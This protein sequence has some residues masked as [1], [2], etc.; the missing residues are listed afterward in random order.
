VSDADLTDLTV[1]P[2]TARASAR[3]V[4]ITPMKARRVVDLVRGLPVEEALTVLK[5]AP[6]D[7]ARHVY[8][9]IASAAANA[10]HNEQMPRDG[11]VVSEAWVD[12]GPTAKRFRPRAQGR[13]YRIR[14]RSSHITVVLTAPEGG[15]R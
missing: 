1:E 7:A 2:R 5:F 14:K 4:G 8:K 11:L 15:T 10:T 12:E 9:V 6:Q 13:A 3:Y